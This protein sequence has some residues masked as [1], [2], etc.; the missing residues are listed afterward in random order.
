MTTSIY[1]LY[2]IYMHSIFRYV[3]RMNIFSKIIKD[4]VDLGWIA[5]SNMFL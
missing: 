1:Q 2:T 4:W 5:V 3:N